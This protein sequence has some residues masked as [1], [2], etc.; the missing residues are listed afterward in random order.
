VARATKKVGEHQLF[1]ELVGSQTDVA[2]RFSPNQISPSAT[3]FPYSSFYPS[4]GAAY[5]DVFN[6]LV[7]VFP[8]SPP[9]AAC[10]SPTAG[11]A[12][13]AATAKSR[14]KPRRPPAGRRR[15][16][17]DLFGWAA[18]TIASACRAPTAKSE[19]TLGT[20][21]NYTVALANALGT[22]IINPSCCRAR[23]RARQALDLIKSTSA[24]GVVLY[25]GKTTLTQFDAPCRAN[26]QAAGRRRHGRV[27]TDL[28]K[29]EYKFNG[30]LRAARPPARRS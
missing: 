22:G 15:R 6:E 1:A 29:E 13:S 11:A 24:E 5:N 18:S 3:T 23:P 4:T 27:G 9:T 2:K 14:P 8:S 25:G 26:L 21:Y 17:G 19:S 12:W 16:S 7:A 10:R 30:D 20:G 28:R